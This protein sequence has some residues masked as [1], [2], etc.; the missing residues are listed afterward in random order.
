MVRFR[1]IRKYLTPSIIHSFPKRISVLAAGH[2]S[3]PKHREDSTYPLVL[4]YA[5]HR[6]VPPQPVL[7][8]KMVW[9]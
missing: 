8:F 2:G 3:A 6:S 9:R 5:A 1:Y 7:S 4:D